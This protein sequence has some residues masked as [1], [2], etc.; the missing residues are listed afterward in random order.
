MVV[1]RADVEVDIDMENTVDGQA[2]LW[3]ALVT[4]GSGE[5]YHPFMTWEPLDTD[6]TA[7]RRLFGE[8][9]RWLHSLIVNAESQDSSIRVYCYSRQAEE[10]HMRLGIDDGDHAL[11]AAVEEFVA[12][13]RWID[14]WRVFESQLITGETKSLKT[15]ARLAGFDW[16]DDDPGGGLSMAWYEEALAGAGASRAR[17][18]A[19]NEDDVRATKALRDWMDHTTFVPIAEWEPTAGAG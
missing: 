15:V 10:R 2:Y 13:E 5:E 11:A 7:R 16:R 9:W 8:F 6:G 14:M 4:D 12:S 1:P 17:L 19:Y 18:L 3:G